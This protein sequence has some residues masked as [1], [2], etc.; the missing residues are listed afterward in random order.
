[1]SQ[2]STI[3]G[4]L[5]CVLFL[6][7]Y[8][9]VHAANEEKA[10]V[11]VS[12]QTKVGLLLDNVP[13]DLLDSVVQKYKTIG[14]KYWEDR[15]KR[16]YKFTW[17]Y[18]EWR[19]YMDDTRHQIAFT[20]EDTWIFQLLDDEPTKETIV[21]DGHTH[22][23]LTMNYKFLTYILTNNE[24]ITISEPDLATIPSSHVDQITIPLDPDFI[25]QRTG[26]SCM[27]EAEFPPYAVD[28]QN[29]W[30]FY[31]FTTVAE[32]EPS[33]ND[34]DMYHFHYTHWPETD[35]SEELAIQVGYI[36]VDYTLN[37]IE[38]DEDIAS[39]F[40][41]GTVVKDGKGADLEVIQSALNTNRIEYKYFDSSSCALN[42]GCIKKKGWRRVLKFSAA[43]M[44]SGSNA[45]HVGSIEDDFVSSMINHNV[46]EWS[47]CHKH[48]HF[49][50]YANYTV[51]SEDG[52]KL[53]D[54]Q[55]WCLESVNRNYNNEDTDINTP[56]WKCG[57][58]GIQVGWSDEYI[59]GIECQW[60]D[61]TPADADVADQKG[62]FVNLGFAAN[63]KGFLCE[64]KPQLDSNGMYKFESSPFLTQISK[65]P[66]DKPL[67]DYREDY[68]KNN[69][70]TTYYYVPPYGSF[71]NEACSSEL[72][73]PLRDC[74]W[75]SLGTV[76]CSPGETVSL[77]AKI[78]IHES[79]RTNAQ[80]IRVC[81][82]SHALMTGVAC[83]YVSN[84]ASAVVVDEASFT[85]TCPEPIEGN[86]VEVGGVVSIYNAPYL[87]SGL[88]QD[89]EI[90]GLIRNPT[91][92][93]N[94]QASL[95]P[96]FLL[97]AV[98]SFIVLVF[99]L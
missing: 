71:I 82:Y 41:R 28:T 40:R 78:D 80:V 68:E 83:S 23:Y 14:S 17:Y 94:G 96:S 55:A 1:M 9:T 11:K 89:I 6:L 86:D 53:G 98:L 74:G 57:Y 43:T 56:Y 36:T 76:K 25:L 44:N 65:K 18:M 79:E 49:Q 16:H 93:V 63:P 77:K 10:L 62:K 4:L 7:S 58:Q 92:Q 37:R 51:Q 60:L 66:M 99:I 21:S 26:Y 70:A 27:D 88:T 52:I 81:D 19:M 91:A 22:T 67:C 61:I 64:G 31:D 54:K 13:S 95:A 48:Y 42:E 35:C 87:S 38:W 72:M 46:Y 5:I 33:A 8:S 24:S 69:E 59:A 2:T 3:L 12:L 84:L 73:G 45:I 30:T 32:D 47:G 15:A 39:I 20:P 34:T 97:L 85:F 75:A 50:F 90:A 29:A